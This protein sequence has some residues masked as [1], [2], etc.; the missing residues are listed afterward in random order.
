MII[1]IVPGDADLGMVKIEFDAVYDKRESQLPD[2][3][4]RMKNIVPSRSYRIM[5]S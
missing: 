1:I 4:Y 5:K 3:F 2:T